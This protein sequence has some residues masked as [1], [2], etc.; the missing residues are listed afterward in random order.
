MVRMGSPVRF[1]RG[2]PCDLSGDRRRPNLRPWVRTSSFPGGALGCPGGLV[3]LGGVEDELAEELAG[4]GVDHADVQVLDEQDDVGSGVG[5]ADADVVQ[6]AGQ[7]QGDAA[8]VVDAVAPDPVVGVGVAAAGGAGFGQAG[9]DGR[10]VARCGRDRCGRRW[11]YSSVNAPS[12]ACSSA[13][14]AGWSGWAASHF[15]RVCWKRSTLP[16]VVGWLG[17]AFFW[18]TPRRRSS[19]SRA[20]RPPLP[21][22]R[23]VVKT[24]ALSVKVEAGVPKRDRAARKRS[25]TAGPV[26]GWWAVTS[27]A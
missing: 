8:A 2:A 22:D 19:A 18:A 26:T 17:R 21:P 7:A 20:L 14:V 6:P 13:T 1:R 16:Q 24:I 5:S 12:R 25:R 11:L 27:R 9:V 23:R 15:L 10:G 4:G 3:V